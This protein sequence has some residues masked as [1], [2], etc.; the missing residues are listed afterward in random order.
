MTGL[1]GTG[2]AVAWAAVLVVSSPAAAHGERPRVVIFGGGWGPEGTQQSLE[3]QVIDLARTLADH[4]PRILFAD[5]STAARTVQI[6]G[7][8]DRASE[9]LGLVFNQ[10]HDLHADYRPTT[11]RPAGPAS[12]EGL[13]QAI[14][15]TAASPHGTIFFGVGHGSPSDA[16]RPAVLE[17]W[18]PEDRMSP[19]ELGEALD[20]P[21][22]GPTAWVLGQC[23]SGAFA[24]L[25]HVGADPDKPLARPARCVF[26]A[27]PADREA[28]GC[29]TDLSDVSAR[30]Y[31]SRMAEAIR[32]A[33]TSDLNGDGRV[34]LGEAHA[35]ARI[36][37]P[38]VDVPVSSVEL[39]AAD[40]LS[41][42]EP[43]ASRFDARR[44]LES[45]PPT[46]A[47][48]M[49]GLGPQYVTR[50]SGIADAQA[51]FRRLDEELRERRKPFD[52]AQAEFD[53]LRRRLFDRLVAKWPELT[54]PYHAASRALLA[55]PA[56]AVVGWL[57]QQPELES[58]RRLE[59]RITKLDTVLIELEKRIARL[60]RWLRSAQHVANLAR[61]AADPSA[62]ATLATFEACV[63]LVP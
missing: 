57:R 42:A 37:D 54:N 5:G 13:V 19:T 14:R 7:P 23:H 39:W 60:E 43:D 28:S 32:S 53:V 21:R 4:R 2:R 59:Q 41:D 51:D 17:L 31:V 24:V 33:S 52:D 16:E 36:H 48:V 55:G 45:A 38:T 58:L 44:L 47:A 6:E 50:R 12:R 26:A 34:D 35:F 3:A 18:G 56:P 40:A 61:L 20:V 63:S 27:V 62:R 30:A 11:L 29:T 8:R 25:A 46:E 9:W 49:R 22:R 15:D 10:R 1:R